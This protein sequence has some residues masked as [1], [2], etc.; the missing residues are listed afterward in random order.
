MEGDECR[1]PHF[2][3]WVAGG[4]VMRGLFDFTHPNWG[5]DRAETQRER[6]LKTRAWHIETFRLFSPLRF[7]PLPQSI[8]APMK[9]SAKVARITVERCRLSHTCRGLKHSCSISF[10]RSLSFR[11]VVSSNCVL[12]FITPLRAE[13]SVRKS[14]LSSQH[15]VSSEKFLWLGNLE[16]LL[17]VLL[18]AVVRFV[19]VRWLTCGGWWTHDGRAV[20]QPDWIFHGFLW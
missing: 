15:A 3:S 7:W 18:F 20:F 9:P 16:E 5:S 12:C 19:E 8:G 6:A 10:G 2:I 17:R 4:R 13:A 1:L 14:L 11:G